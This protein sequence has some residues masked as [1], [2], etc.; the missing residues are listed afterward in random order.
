MQNDKI[1]RGFCLVKAIGNFSRKS[2]IL[3]RF[4]FIYDESMYVS[5]DLETTGIDPHKDRIIEFGAIKFDLNGTYEKLSFLVNPGVTLPQIITHITK[6]TDN[7]LKNQP[8]IKEKIEEIKNFIGD[9]PLIGHNIQFDTSFLKNIGL[10]ANN[11]EYDTFNF[12]SILFPN[13]PS[14]SLEILSSIL[15][16]KH[17]EKHR[18]LDDAIAAME[19][20]IKLIG[21]FQTLPVKTFDEIQ[22]I[23]AKSNWKLKDLILSLTHKVATIRPAKEKSDDTTKKITGNP[24][25]NTSKTSDLIQK[26]ENSLFEIPAPYNNLT[27]TLLQNSSENTYVCVDYELFN[28]LSPNMAPEIAQ[29]DAPENYLS[30][31]RLKELEQK[32]FLEEHEATSLIKLL[33]WSRKTKTGLLKEINLL[34]PEK[35]VIYQVNADP[36]M[37]DVNGELFIQKAVKKDANS[38]AICTFKYLMGNNSQKMENLII[39]EF[40]KFIKELFYKNSVHLKEDYLLYPLNG[41]KEINPENQSIES[42]IS[43]TTILF[44]LL[45]IIFNKYNNQDLYSPRAIISQQIQS[46]KDWED[47][48]SAINN[49]I[50]ISKELG[51]ILGPKT[52]GYLQKWK[53][54]LAE[55]KSIFENPDLEKFL[56]FIETDYLGNITVHKMPI[57]LTEAIANI[58]HGCGNYKLVDECFDINDDGKFIKKFYGLPE[59]L[60]IIKIPSQKSKTEISIT[61]KDNE[62]KTIIDIL[63]ERKGKAAVVFNSKKQIEFSTTK[64]ENALRKNDLTIISQLTGSIG[65]LE[66]KFAKSPEKSIL[67]ITPA[68][69]ER[70]RYNNLINT[71]IIAK[72]PFDAPGNLYLSALSQQFTNPFVELQIPR[73]MIAVKKILNRLTA[74]NPKVYFLD[75]RLREKDYC[76]PIL[77]MIVNYSCE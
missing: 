52:Q 18:A 5:L 51:S 20:F 59:E 27:L 62:L 60:K 16:L 67:L 71:L 61:S 33:I 48:N 46:T 64:L 28:E 19:L 54:K 45:G 15:N 36:E 32:P 37:T 70:F 31:Q 75:P 6:I 29:L 63:A 40:E 3:I 57:S 14:Y 23:A 49:L 58:L 17:K 73:A 12:A 39:V 38:P 41:L 2:I 25:N 7:D 35:T 72:I 65:K 21:T 44:G 77:D 1:S 66:E 55:L 47:V 9:L 69:W 76:A 74:E 26:T 34:G 53:K 22:K 4:T 42:L 56:I 24:D 30:P 43:K 10:T 8:P 13:L 50:S 11:P 68:I